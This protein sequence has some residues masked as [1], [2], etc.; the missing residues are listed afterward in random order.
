MVLPVHAARRMGLGRH[1]AAAAGGRGLAGAGSQ[2]AVA[3]ESQRLL[4]CP[5]SCYGQ[6]YGGPAVRQEAD[7]AFCWATAIS[8]TDGKAL[9]RAT[10]TGMRGGGFSTPSMCSTSIIPD[11]TAPEGRSGWGQ[12]VRT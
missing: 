10:T 9:W 4:L 1:R 8:T 6:R 7:V 2:A 12:C 5:R 3:G 11:T